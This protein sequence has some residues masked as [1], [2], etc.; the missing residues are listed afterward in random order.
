V[1]LESIPGIAHRAVSDPTPSRRRHLG[2]WDTWLGRRLVRS[3]GGGRGRST[4]RE[5]DTGQYLKSAPHAV[6]PIT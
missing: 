4:P 1:S 5:R 3:T 2:I 6:W